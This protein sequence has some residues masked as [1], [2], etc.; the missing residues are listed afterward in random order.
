MKDLFIKSR[1]QNIWKLCTKRILDDMDI[2]DIKINLH[3]IEQC[4]ED[5]EERLSRLNE[6]SN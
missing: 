6:K 5:Y 1:I 4:I 2:L 3:Q